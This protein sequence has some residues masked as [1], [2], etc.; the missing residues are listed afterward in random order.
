[1]ACFDGFR[2][3]DLGKGE[4]ASCKC[5]AEKSDGQSG[6]LDVMSKEALQLI[7]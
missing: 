3:Y 4:F 1:M 6:G 5:Q 7:R 2:K